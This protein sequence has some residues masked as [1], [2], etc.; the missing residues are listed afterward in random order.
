M[1]TMMGSSR[2][3]TLAARRCRPMGARKPGNLPPSSCG[4]DKVSVTNMRGNGG[5]A[6]PV[7]AT[8]SAS[9]RNWA[10]AKG[11]SWSSNAMILCIA[12]ATAGPTAPWPSSAATAA[13]MWR[14]T[15]S[16]KVPV[17]VAGSATVTSFEAMP[18]VN[19]KP[20]RRST[21]STSRTMP[22]TTSG[23]V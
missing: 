2:L 21:S 23:G 20:G 5:A 7:N 6:R 19:A 17:P 22:D 11:P 4:F 1:T 9:T 12:A 10:T 16:T 13:A 14:S 18:R 15:P 3:M 8:A